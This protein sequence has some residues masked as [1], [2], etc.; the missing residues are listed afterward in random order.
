[1]EKAHLQLLPLRY[2]F[3]ER[4][5]KNNTSVQPARPKVHVAPHILGG[6]TGTS[7]WTGLKYTTRLIFWVGKQVTCDRPGLKYTLRLIFWVRKQ[8]LTTGQ[9]SAPHIFVE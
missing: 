8:V 2:D 1:M 6:K 3:Y 7:D 5:S 9:A 4:K